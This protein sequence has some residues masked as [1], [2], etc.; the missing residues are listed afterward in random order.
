MYPGISRLLI[1]GCTFLVLAAFVL[2][3]GCLSETVAN[4]TSSGTLHAHFEHADSWSPGLGCYAHTTGYVYNA[5]NISADNVLL[6]MNLVNIR[7]SAIRDSRQ[8]Y[9]GTLAPGKTRPFE[10]NLDGECSQDYQVEAYL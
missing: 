10:T 5:G 2:G 8:I 6:K 4:D 7:T 3:A 1:G 9:I